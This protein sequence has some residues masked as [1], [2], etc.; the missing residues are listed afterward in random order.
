METRLVTI[1]EPVARVCSTGHL[2]ILEL[3]VVFG[4]LSM[5]KKH[6]N[7]STSKVQQQLQLFY[8]LKTACQLILGP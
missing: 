1:A 5:E 7:Q 2:E 6:V 8:M 4:E 3:S